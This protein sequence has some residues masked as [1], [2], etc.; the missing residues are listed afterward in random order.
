MDEKNEKKNLR[1]INET[2]PKEDALPNIRM[3]FGIYTTKSFIENL[4]SFAGKRH[5]TK[6]KTAL[7][8]LP[9]TVKM[10]TVIKKTSMPFKDFEAHN[11]YIDEKQ[12]QYDGDDVNFTGYSIE[13]FDILFKKT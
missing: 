1:A 8:P 5:L 12:L 6:P 9:C 7:I 10:G 4:N 13:S 2:N 3:F 11:T